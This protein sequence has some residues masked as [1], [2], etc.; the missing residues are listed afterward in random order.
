MGLRQGGNVAGSRIFGAKGPKNSMLVYEVFS[1]GFVFGG[2]GTRGLLGRRFCVTKAFLVA[3][4]GAGHMTGDTGCC[5]I[6]PGPVHGCG[7]GRGLLIPAMAQSPEAEIDAYAVKAP[8]SGLPSGP[9]SQWTV[10]ATAIHIRPRTG[11]LPIPLRRQIRPIPPSPDRQRPSGP[12]HC[13]GMPGS[14]HRGAPARGL[15]PG[16]GARS[17]TCAPIT[18][19]PSSSARRCRGRCQAS[20]G[21]G[22][23]RVVP[24]ANRLISKAAFAAFDGARVRHV[25]RTWNA[26]F[27]LNAVKP[28]KLWAIALTLAMRCLSAPPAWK[29]M[30]SRAHGKNGRPVLPPLIRQLRSEGYWVSVFF[31]DTAPPDDP[32]VLGGCGN[33]RSLVSPSTSSLNAIRSAVP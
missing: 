4:E 22:H 28:S 12:Q 14:L 33:W 21:R 30:P 18:T 10:A 27:D 15:P 26:L 5:R 11:V 16:R 6:A 23:G 2:A 19:R 3:A 9:Y 17:R 13:Q 29:T 25:P 1:E 7:A 24:H 31:H 20:S 32:S 8:I